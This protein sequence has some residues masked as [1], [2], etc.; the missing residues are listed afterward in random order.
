[1][2]D[3]WRSGQWKLH[4]AWLAA[5]DMKWVFMVFQCILSLTARFYIILS[6]T[7]ILYFVCVM[8][9]D[10]T[11]LAVSSNNAVVASS[12]NDFIIRVVSSSHHLLMC[13][14]CWNFS[15]ICVLS[16][17]LIVLPCQC[18]GVYLM[19]IQYQCWRGMLELWL[20]L[21]LVPGLRL[22]TSCFRKFLHYIVYR[23]MPLLNLWHLGYPVMAL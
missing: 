13:C 15:L 20:L 8:K 21:P 6:L 3:L 19:D 11:D 4:F 10:I 23:F 2:I 16:Q 1:M 7:I 22:F 17:V 9:G 18:S 14:L 12:A 5:E